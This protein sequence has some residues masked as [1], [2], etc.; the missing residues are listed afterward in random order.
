MRFRNKKTGEIREFNPVRINS[1][2]LSAQQRKRLFWC[3]WKVEQ[4]ED[5]GI[6]LR[7]ILEYGAFTDREKS[8]PILSTYYRTGI[9]RKLKDYTKGCRQ[10]VFETPHR[11]GDIGSNSQAHRVYSVNGKSVCLSSQGG[12][13]GAKTGLYLTAPQSA[14]VYSVNGK[15]TCLQSAK[16]G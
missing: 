2:K 3:N 15:S 16:G 5:R 4:P 10:L 7:D 14:R 12:G 6:Y 11:I 1:A 13:Q 9:E 8:Y